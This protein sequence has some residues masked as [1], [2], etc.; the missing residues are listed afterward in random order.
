MPRL[1]YGLLPALALTA[2]G[3]APDTRGNVAATDPAAT[4]AVADPLMTDPELKRR[5]NAD[6]MRPPDEPFQALVPPGEPDP[7]R[8][9]QPPTLAA[10]MAPKLAAA[11]FAGCPRQVG[12]SYG[13][14]ARLPEG[15]ALPSDARV[16][17]AG[18]AD[19]DGCALRM[20]AY[21]SDTAPATLAETYRRAAA[22]SGFSLSESSANGTTAISAMQAQ[23]GGSFVATIYAA[24]RGGSAVDLITNRGR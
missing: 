3:S 17:E 8:A 7:F 21:N 22:S 24:P 18:G 10:R 15:L 6:V 13:W 2:C 12:V 5:S 16:A 4:A 9:G 23:G 1:S 11:P 20:V 19:A 14:A